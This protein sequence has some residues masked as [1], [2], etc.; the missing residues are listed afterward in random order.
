MAR[1]KSNKPLPT[2]T[3]RVKKSFAALEAAGGKRVTLRLTPQGVDALKVIMENDN[4]ATETSAIND[5]LVRRSRDIHGK[6]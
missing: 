6:K 5:T 4:I 2:A 1:P 3:E